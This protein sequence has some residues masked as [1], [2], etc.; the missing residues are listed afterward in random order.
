MFK[1]CLL[2]VLVLVVAECGPLPGKTKKYSVTDDISKNIDK[3]YRNAKKEY[4]KHASNA[5]D[6]GNQ[7]EE[8][9]KQFGKDAKKHVMKADKAAKDVGEAIGKFFGLKK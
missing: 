4:K 9:A 1:F 5:K 8:K 6:L 3:T 2:L 7:L